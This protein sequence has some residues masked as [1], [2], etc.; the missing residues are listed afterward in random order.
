MKMLC[1]LYPFSRGGDHGVGPCIAPPLGRVCVVRRPLHN[2]PTS[3]A[4]GRLPF[5]SGGGSATSPLWTIVAT[6]ASSV[7]AHADSRAM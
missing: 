5:V 2:Q 3:L 4:G 7:P 6:G 1:R